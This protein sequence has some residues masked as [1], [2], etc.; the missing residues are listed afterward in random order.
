[1]RVL[2]VEDDDNKAAQLVA[3]I[4]DKFQADVERT[5][6]Y[7]SGLQSLLTQKYDIC[8]LDMALPTFDIR[9]DEDGY[10]PRFYGGKD[11]LRQLQRRGISL[12]VIVVTMF[13]TFGE[14]T[15]RRSLNEINA[16]LSERFS[17]SYV[18]TIYYQ[19]SNEDWKHQ[20]SALVFR[21]TQNGG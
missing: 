10:K 19:P 7:Q 17:Q 13:E 12:P 5:G 11:I 15:E 9:P 20:L 8:L 2:I 18:G 1:V 3:F 14:G 4:E 6:S 16:E 21:H